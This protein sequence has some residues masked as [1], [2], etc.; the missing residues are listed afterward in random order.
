MTQPL[1]YIHSLRKSSNAYANALQ[2]AFWVIALIWVIWAIASSFFGAPQIPGSVRA[3]FSF[4]SLAWLIFFGAAALIDYTIFA[5]LRALTEWITT[6]YNLAMNAQNIEPSEEADQTNQ[7][8][9][10][11]AYLSD[12]FKQPRQ[13][14]DDTGP[15]NPTPAA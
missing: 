15:L 14:D 5:V 7:R 9:S 8:D 3:L 2:I 13:S 10:A 11:V 4:I 12:Y 6:W 1:P